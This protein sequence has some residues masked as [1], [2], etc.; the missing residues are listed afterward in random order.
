MCMIGVGVWEI[1]L[2]YVSG[3]FWIVYVVIFIEVVY[4]LYC[5]CK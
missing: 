3:V 5:L 4:V 1:C 2:C